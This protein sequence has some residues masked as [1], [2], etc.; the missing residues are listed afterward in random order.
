MYIY[1]NM[2]TYYRALGYAAG[3]S[4]LH[5]RQRRRPLGEQT[6]QQLDVISHKVCLESSCKSQFPYK[7]V[8]LFIVLIIVKDR[9]TDLSGNRP[10]NRLDDRLHVRQRR[11]PLGEQTR[12]QVDFV[13]QKVFMNWF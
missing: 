1:M 2:Y 8:N 3:R 6:R 7:S 4:R 13:P 12:Q 10:R 11:R 9:L 5:V